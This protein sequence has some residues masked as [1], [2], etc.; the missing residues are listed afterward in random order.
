MSHSALCW[1]GLTSST[2]LIF[3]FSGTRQGERRPYRA[4]LGGRAEA[5]GMKFNKTK[6]RV[7]HFG[8]NTPR[9]RDRLGAERLEDCIEETDRGGLVDAR[10]NM[11]QQCARVTKQASWLVSEIVWPAGAGK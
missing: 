9:Q 4:V 5:S 3:G 7:V 2:V 11:S 1:C 10:L 8:H 6:C